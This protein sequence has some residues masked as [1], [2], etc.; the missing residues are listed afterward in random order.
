MSEILRRLA[1][2]EELARRP[3]AESAISGTWTPTYLGAT[4]PGTTTYTVQVGTYTRIDN[5]VFFQVY[6]AWTAATGTGIA[7]ISLPFTSVSTTNSNRAVSV[8]TDGVTFAN[9]SVQALISPN[10]AYV[11]LFSPLSNGVGTAVAVEAA[12]LIVLG[13]MYFV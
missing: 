1:A 3:R 13:G 2:L 7:N 5:V 10:T 12:G 8:G 4:T 11:Y 6:V 9:G